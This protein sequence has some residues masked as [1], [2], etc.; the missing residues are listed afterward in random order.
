MPCPPQPCAVD[1][2]VGGGGEKA[3]ALSLLRTSSFPEHLVVILALVATSYARLAA[4]IVFVFSLAFSQ[5]F[6][7]LQEPFPGCSPILHSFPSV[8]SAFPLSVWLSCL[9]FL[10]ASLSYFPAIPDLIFNVSTFL[11]ETEIDG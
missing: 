6:S 5:G 1:P 10:P 7:S 3:F 4:K 2:E 11:W 8:L 9:L